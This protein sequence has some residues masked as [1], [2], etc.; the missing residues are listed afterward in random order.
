MTERLENFIEGLKNIFPKAILAGAGVLG[1]ATIFGGI[2][3]NL[4]AAQ[5]MGWFCTLIIAAFVLAFVAA[6][7]AFIIW[8]L[9]SPPWVLL[10]TL[11][12]LIAIVGVVVVFIK[13]LGGPLVDVESMLA[14][15]LSF[16][17]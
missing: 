14:P 1:V 11:G 17:K 8:F 15:L 2:C 5:V 7:V 12:A 6:L 16:L 10:G 13:L 3:F 4:D 9:I